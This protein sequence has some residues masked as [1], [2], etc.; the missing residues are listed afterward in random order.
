MS[1]DPPAYTQDND[2]SNLELSNLS[3]SGGFCY[4]L[5]QKNDFR[6]LKKQ[7]IM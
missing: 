1:L 3:F 6:I 5:A 7:L 2:A 4:V